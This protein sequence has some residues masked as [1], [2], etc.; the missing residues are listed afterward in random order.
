MLQIVRKL[1]LFSWKMMSSF[2]AIIC[3]SCIPY[4]FDHFRPDFNQYV[5]K[6][7]ELLSALTS[8]QDLE[9]ST[10]RN[11]FR[12]IFPTIL[13][14][15]RES[16]VLVGGSLVVSM[17]ISIV[18]AFAI[19]NL[20]SN[21]IRVFQEIFTYIQAVPD[22]FYIILLQ[23]FI[24]WLYQKTNIQF[25]N[26]ASFGE[27]QAIFL[28]IL[29]LSITPTMIMTKL[30]ISQILEEL[31]KSYTNLALAKGLSFRRMIF[32]H[33]LRNTIYSLFHYSKTI[34]LF[35]LTN[36]LIV[37]Y[38]FNIPGIMSFILQYPYPEVFFIGIMLIYYPIFLL[39]Q[40][41]ELFVPKVIKE[42]GA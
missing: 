7:V 13:P 36:L 25:L 38:L 23:I 5:R 37:E 27:E 39:F 19:V 6:I 28:P 3:I 21:R 41:Y 32:V 29:S 4:L 40:C 12:P 9:F 14:P 2:L 18:I 20:K 35:F 42:G 11:V 8:L 17:L 15:L 33:V 1:V 16:L 34:I 10:G 26:F 31:T 22:I 30:F 24:V